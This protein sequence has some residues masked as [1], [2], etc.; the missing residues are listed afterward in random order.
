M[1]RKGQYFLFS[2]AHL[3]GD[4]HRGPTAGEIRSNHTD[5]VACWA[6][7]TNYNEKGFFV[8][9]GYFIGGDRP[10]KKLHKALRAEIDE[11]AWVVLAPGP[12]KPILWGK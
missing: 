7:D 3:W 1:G 6:V 5:D 9:H 2:Y 12:N 10:Y 8:R 11:T 4:G